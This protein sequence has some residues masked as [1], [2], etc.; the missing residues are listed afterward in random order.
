MTSSYI[1]GSVRVEKSRKLEL[2]CFS[3]DFREI[4]YRGD[5]EMLITKRRP[6]LTLENY[7]RKKCNFLPILDKII[8]STLQQLHCHGN[9]GC[10]M[11]LVCIPNLSLSVYSKS[12]KV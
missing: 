8:P 4:W 9:C 7:L 2:L 6:K 3:S 5:F 1:L 12:H 11:G 10:P